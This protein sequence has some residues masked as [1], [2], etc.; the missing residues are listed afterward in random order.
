MIRRRAPFACALL[1]GALVACQGAG[2]AASDAGGDAQLEGRAEAGAED[3]ATWRD[4]D[5]GSVSA[6]ALEVQAYLSDEN[7]G[8]EPPL[9]QKLAG[10]Y[11]DLSFQALERAVRTR[12]DS[13][14]RLRAGIREERWTNPFTGKE[15][16]YHAVVTRRVA[17]SP[18]P[19][20]LVLFLH[21]AGGNGESVA[22]AE[23]LQA[24]ADRL[25]ALLVAPTSDGTCDWNSFEE[26]MSQVVLLVPL[27][28]RRYPIDDDR[29]VLTGFSM[30]G[31][32]SLS[33][34]ATYPEPYCGVVPFAGAIGAVHPSTN[35][36]DHRIYCCPH[37]ENL[38]G[39]RVHHTVGDQDMQLMVLQNRACDSC[40]KAQ[41]SESIYDELAGQGHVFPVE[42][43][44]VAVS[45]ALERAR[46]PYPRRVV[47]QR[48][49]HLSA[50]VA[51]GLFFQTKLLAPQYWAVMEAPRDPTKP[52]RLEAEVKGGEIHLTASNVARVGLYLAD[53]LVALDAP[54]RVLL[55][56]KVLHEGKV[57]RDR[58]L[59]LTEAHRRAERSMLFAAR[60]ALDLPP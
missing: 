16:R 33:V 44:R 21:G 41:R 7:P 22:R 42:R 12:V 2:P 52:S 26:C 54:V 38:L 58:A 59:L 20:P 31:R 5:P 50:Y 60:L 24:V 55:G 47:Y 40:L 27:L 28:K 29:V 13:P 1:G 34:A 39:L 35:V 6:L 53:E 32:G 4:G 37:A 15:N 46:Q 56:G 8:A 49:K 30:G 23:S 11:R 18:G 10:P 9:L 51:G 36:E 14:R 17:A 19:V 3:A 45:W 57:A 48:A 25:G 43:W